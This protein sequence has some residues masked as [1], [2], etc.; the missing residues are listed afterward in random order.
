MI[1]CLVLRANIASSI[2]FSPNWLT[3]LGLVVMLCKRQAFD[4]IKGCV[5][6]LRM[7]ADTRH[8]HQS[9]TITE[10]AAGCANATEVGSRSGLLS[11]LHLLPASPP[12]V[13]VLVG[14]KPLPPIRPA[15]WL[16]LN[17]T[18]LC[19]SWPR[20][21]SGVKYTPLITGTFRA[22]TR[23]QLA[24]KAKQMDWAALQDVG[25]CR[26]RGKSEM[27]YHKITVFQYIFA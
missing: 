12:F 26:Q 14:D 22:A 17:V 25:T 8:Q 15:K 10:P 9:I 18:S 7:F 5:P 23:A 2:T 24:A 11:P 16:K 1:Q 27:L 21:T 6:Q 4:R 13:P 20:V 19:C 3:Y